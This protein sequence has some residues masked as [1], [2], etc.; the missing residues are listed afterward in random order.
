MEFLVFD[1]GNYRFREDN[2]NLPPPGNDRMRVV[3]FTDVVN[4][5]G[6]IRNDV[7][8]MFHIISNCLRGL[9]PFNVFD[10]FTFREVKSATAFTDKGVSATVLNVLSATCLPLISNSTIRCPSGFCVVVFEFGRFRHMQHAVLRIGCMRHHRLQ[11]FT[12][13]FHVHYVVS[14]RIHTQNIAEQVIIVIS[15]MV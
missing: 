5:H 14:K 6:M 10:I 12:A 11:I 15:I 2:I 7:I 9:Q 3:L 4:T 8:D 13:N 1:N